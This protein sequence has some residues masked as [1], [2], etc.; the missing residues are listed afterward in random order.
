[1]RGS[2][3]SSCHAA[4]MPENV[5]NVQRKIVYKTGFGENAQNQTTSCKK[6]IN[7]LSEEMGFAIVK[8]LA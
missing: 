7:L 5:Y 1:M 3:H 4:I 2:S 8:M 6:T